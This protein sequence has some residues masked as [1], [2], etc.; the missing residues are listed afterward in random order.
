MVSGT[1]A[2]LLVLVIVIIIL[3]VVIALLVRKKKGKPVLCMFTSVILCLCHNPKGTCILQHLCLTLTRIDM[4]ISH[5]A[6]STTTPVTSNRAGE[7][8]TY[9]IPGVDLQQDALS[10]AHCTS[11]MRSDTA[12]FNNTIYGSNSSVNKDTV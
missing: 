6:L 9:G 12:G 2:A 8:P 10:G 11:T 5:T 3:L 4:S 1:V 7:N